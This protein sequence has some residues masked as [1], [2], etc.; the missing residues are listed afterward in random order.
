MKM[1]RYLVSGQIKVLSPLSLRTGSE[2]EQW[3]GTAAREP[4][5][6][7]LLDDETTTAPISAVELDDRGQPFIPGS[8]LKGLL[9]AVVSLVSG[10]ID[11]DL[12]LRLFGDMPQE[13]RDAIDPSAKATLGG[14]AEFGNCYIGTP[15]NEWRPA[16][17]G[18]TALHEGSR[19]A[20]DGQLRHD[21]IVAPGTSFEVN[22]ILDRA[23]DT[24]VQILL[25]LLALLDGR[26][27]ES[28]VGSGTSQG[29]GRIMWIAGERPASRFGP[30]EAVT[31][32]GDETG[33]TWQ[34]FAVP[35]ALAPHQFGGIAVKRAT[36]DLS[37]EIS[38]H[39][40]VSA[41]EFFLNHEDREKRRNRPYRVSGD[42]DTTARLAGSTLDGALRAQARRIYRTISGDL[43][44]W[45]DDDTHLPDAFEKLFGSSRCASLLE[46]ET[47]LCAGKALTQQ[48]FVAV[49]RFSGG[50]AG[51]AQFSIRAFEAP[52]LNGT[53]SLVL[54]RKPRADITGK[55]GG[56][57]AVTATPA[58]VG[59]LALTLKDLACGDIALGHATRK[60][61]GNVARV[62]GAGG[63]EWPDLLEDLGRQAVEAGIVPV[64][65]GSGR[66][67]IE[68]AVAALQ[69]EVKDWAVQRQQND[70]VSSQ[71]GE[72][73]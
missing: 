54:E 1:A 6:E 57:E 22:I 59:L 24:D 11:I 9:R 42:D 19:T 8:A 55:P 7:P 34:E 28:A 45:S 13:G 18:R 23:N 39:F 63:H 49:D 30:E 17:R 21:R 33:A 36:V 65:H 4:N 52:V 26:T 72:G 27:A 48:E 51:Q 35:A 32:L 29:D 38:G 41:Q 20:E 56:T 46:T 53:L 60:G 64:A 50:A 14:V 31:W 16:I 66:A 3:R 12:V 37:I 40:L 44:P 58:A 61:Y 43:A 62:S 5:A 15:D 10:D 68:I 71:R 70:M 47:F 25:G 69:Q 67:G 73:A 2:E